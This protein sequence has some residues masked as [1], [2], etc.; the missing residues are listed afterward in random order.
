MSVESAIE[1]LRKAMNDDGIDAKRGLGID[2]FHFASTLMPVVNVDLL[3]IND[4]HEILLSWRDDEHCGR[5]WHIP[6][7]CIRLGET[8]YERIQ[9]TALAE[10]GS[11]VE[12]NGTPIEVFEIFTSEYR[13]NISNQN[14][15]SHFVTLVFLCRLPEG[16]HV[17]EKPENVPGC[18]KWFRELPHDLV[19]V[20]NCYKDKWSQIIK[21]VGGK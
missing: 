18:L 12:T 9:K 2:L 4:N 1:C 21:N 20:Q 13:P 6:G 17:E 19:N 8:F 16:Y 14:E 5:G 10:L 11:E 7:G 3:V 15:R